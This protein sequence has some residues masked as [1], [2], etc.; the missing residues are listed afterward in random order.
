MALSRRVQSL[1]R[2]ADALY[3]CSPRALMQPLLTAPPER[4]EMCRTVDGN[5][6]TNTLGGLRD[7]C[8]QAVFLHRAARGRLLA[9]GTTEAHIEG[10]AQAALAEDVFAAEECGRPIS[11]ERLDADCAPQLGAHSLKEV[12]LGRRAHAQQVRA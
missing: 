6:R 8:D 7:A 12:L 2:L 11:A 9:E 4:R 10:I 3:V 1:L 5:G